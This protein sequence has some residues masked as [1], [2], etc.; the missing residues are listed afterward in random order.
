M[1][2]NINYTL[3]GLIFCILTIAM[4]AFIFWIGRF[5]IDVIEE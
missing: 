2:R 5:G 4:I 1:E 3:I